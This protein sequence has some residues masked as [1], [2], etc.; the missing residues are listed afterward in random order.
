[1]KK[2]LSPV[3][4]IGTIAAAIVLIVGVVWMLM[5]RSDSAK[6]PSVEMQQKQMDTQKSLVDGYIQGSQGG[7]EAAARQQHPGG[8][9]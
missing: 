7:G 2:E 3:A 1:M 4:M 6:E 5:S 9:Q 8:G